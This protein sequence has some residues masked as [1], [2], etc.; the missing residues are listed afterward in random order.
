MISLKESKTSF[1][2]SIVEN[3]EST[4][5][6]NEKINMVAE[7]YA[8]AFY[9]YAQALD[10]L[11]GNADPLEIVRYFAEAEINYK[12]TERKVLMNKNSDEQMDFNVFRA[13]DE[14]WV[15]SLQTHSEVDKIAIDEKI[16]LWRDGVPPSGNPKC[17][18][19]NSNCVGNTKLSK[20]AFAGIITAVGVVVIVAIGLGYFCYRRWTTNNA[21]KKLVILIPEADIKLKPEMRDNR[22][23]ST[24]N[25]SFYSGMR[26]FS[27]SSRNLSVSSLSSSFSSDF[28]I[29]KSKEGLRLKLLFRAK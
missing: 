20:G 18:L 3:C 29:S 21:S 4:N 24:T 16:S 22:P 12:Q 17:G 27:R 1:R 15:L 7:S 26:S 11:G 9:G 13:I 10:E 2:T 14:R 25:N 28:P 8:D 5:D 6:P 23:T 19:D